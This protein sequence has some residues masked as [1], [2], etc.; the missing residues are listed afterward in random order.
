MDRAGRGRTGWHCTLAFLGEVDDR[1]LPGL[2]GVLESAASRTEV[3][4]LRIQGS[5]HFGN[6]ALWA[7]VGG[8]VDELGLLAG[9]VGAAA[10]RAGVP[11]DD[12]RSYRPH[13]TL[14]RSGREADL[15][16]YVEELAGFEGAPWLVS[17]IALVRSHLPPG[18]PAIPDGGRSK[19]PRYETLLRFPLSGPGNPADSGAEAGG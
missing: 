11:V 16:P 1:L 6:R 2:F 3:F 17:D 14:A 18:G 12:T 15:R 10:R 8:G 19:E 5:G 9:R 4:P 7:G 13:V